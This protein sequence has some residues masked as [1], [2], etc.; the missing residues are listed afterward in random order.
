VEGDRHP[1]TLVHPSQIWCLKGGI[2]YEESASARDVRNV[3]DGET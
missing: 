1:S 3:K 2:D